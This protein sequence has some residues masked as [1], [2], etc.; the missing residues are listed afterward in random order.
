MCIKQEPWEA[1]E[2]LWEALGPRQAPVVV[3]G[4]AGA[5]ETSAQALIHA[6]QTPG[7]SGCSHAPVA[8]AHAPP[9]HS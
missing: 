7:A 3:A 2:P 4:V 1:L 5:P 6:S 8:G 9:D